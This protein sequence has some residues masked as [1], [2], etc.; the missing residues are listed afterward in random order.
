MSAEAHPGPL[1]W[2]GGRVRSL[3]FDLAVAAIPVAAHLYSHGGRLG[4]DSPPAVAALLVGFGAL[5]VR[6]RFPFAVALVAA[7]VGLFGDPVVGVAEIAL[8]TVASRCGARWPTWAAGAVNLLSLLVQQTVLGEFTWDHTLALLTTTASRAAL[9]VLFG[10]WARQRRSALADYRARADQI[11]RERELL[12]E[13]AVVTERRR[14]AREMHDVVAHRVGI[15]SLHAGA[16]AVNAPDEASGELAET[17]RATSSTAMQELRDML[18]V[19]RDEDTDPESTT[20]PALAG[21]TDLVDDAVRAG[22]NIRLSAPDPMPALPDSAG[23]AA[24]RVVQEG[25]TNAAK[26]APNAAVRVHVAEHREDV[27]VTVTNDPAPRENNAELP[28]SGFGLVGMRERVALAGGHVT[29]G[30]T[31]DGG[32]RV[33]ATFPRS[34]ET[35]Q[36]R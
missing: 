18:R 26:H 30:P 32:Y 13:R 17:I 29:S 10:L 12:A 35:E 3:V 31:D 22:A 2:W 21:I 1:T 15:V 5:A 4:D 23:R 28:R 25:L 7:V 8:Y 36:S 11:E 16:L 14:I 24:Y 34:A 27:G 33:H 6:R 9:P 19:L 20:A